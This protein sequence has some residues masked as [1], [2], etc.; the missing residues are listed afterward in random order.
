MDLFFIN[1]FKIALITKTNKN[2]PD[3]IKPKLINILIDV[4]A[5][6]ISIPATNNKDIVHL[7]TDNNL[8]NCSNVKRVISAKTAGVIS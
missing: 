5:I 7:L 6:M 8:G 1:R 4:E 2:N 3:K